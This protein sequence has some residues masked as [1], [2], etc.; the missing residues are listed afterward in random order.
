MIKII[1]F[2][3]LFTLSVFAEDN[4]MKEDGTFDWENYLDGDME[5]RAYSDTNALIQLFNHY[6][7]VKDDPFRLQTLSNDI[8]ENIYNGYGF[9]GDFGDARLDHY[10]D[11]DKLHNMYKILYD[12][13]DKFDVEDSR[14]KKES[15]EW[16]LSKQIHEVKLFI[17][18]HSAYSSDYAEDKNKLFKIE[19][20]NSDD[21]VNG[22]IIKHNGRVVPGIL[23]HKIDYEYTIDYNGKKDVKI[24]YAKLRI[25]T[26]TVRNGFF[27]ADVLLIGDSQYYIIYNMYNNWDYNY[28]I[29]DLNNHEDTITSVEIIK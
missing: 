28:K 1:I 3:M 17:E 18:I 26:K 12:N 2:F 11:R 4:Y 8:V 29:R 5:G 20:R 14:K 21:E 19:L 10:S 6:D 27:D 15:L 24:K 13:I 23:G 7:I 16:F 9:F 25:N 22:L